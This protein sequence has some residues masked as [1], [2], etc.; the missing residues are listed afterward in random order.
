MAKTGKLTIAY[1][2]KKPADEFQGVT[3][4][5]YDLVV[6]QVETGIKTVIVYHR[7]GQTSIANVGRRVH[8]VTYDGPKP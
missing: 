5:D 3:P 4:K 8:S 6:Q 2:D 1:K 7:G